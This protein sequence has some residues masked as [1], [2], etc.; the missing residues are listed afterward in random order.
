MPPEVQDKSSPAWNKGKIYCAGNEREVT[1]A[2]FAQFKLD[3]G[4]FLESRGQELVEGGLVLIQMPGVPNGDGVLP[5]H[6][7]AGLIHELLGDS[8]IDMANMVRSN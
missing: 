2:Y 3:M 8:L 6:T 5:S 1:K 7:G 4:A